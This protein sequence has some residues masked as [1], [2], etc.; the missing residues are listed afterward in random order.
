MTNALKSDYGIQINHKRVYRLMKSN[1]FLSVIKAKVKYI[2]P[3]EPH[4]KRNILRR[5]FDTSCPFDKLATDVTE[6]SKG[7][8]KIY[9]SS[10]KDLHTGM[11]ESFEISKHPSLA[12]AIAT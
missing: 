5:N 3:G 9:L 6:M 8:I 7:G 1:G 10:I 2:K 12:L 11:I 4:P